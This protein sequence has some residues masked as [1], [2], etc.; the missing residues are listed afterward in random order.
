MFVAEDTFFRFR[1]LVVVDRISTAVAAGFNSQVL[2]PHTNNNFKN[3]VDREASG[4]GR[5]IEG[6]EVDCMNAEECIY[7]FRV[8]HSL[9]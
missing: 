8:R 2:L 1:T 4:I 9:R 3:F 6:I 7:K 5:Y